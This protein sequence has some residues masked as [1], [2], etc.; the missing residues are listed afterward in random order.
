MRALVVTDGHVRIEVRPDPEPG[1]GEVLVRVRAA[2]LN[3]ADLAQRIGRYP[4]PPGSPADIPGLE[5]A[6][7]VVGHGAGVAAPAMGTRVF[8]IVGGGAQAELLAVP[9]GQ[10]AVVPDALDLVAAGGV[11]EAFLTAHDAMITISNARAGEVLFV[12]AAGS[13]VGTAAIQLGKAFGLTTV[14]SARTASKLDAAAA[15]GLDHALLAPRELDPQAFAEQL[16]AAAGPVDIALDLVGGPYPAAEVIAAATRGRIVLIG[17]MAGVPPPLEIG[18]LMAKRL[19]IQGTV[20]RPRTL[21]EKADATRAFMRDALGFFADGS[22]GPVVAEVAPLADGDAAYD[23][24]AAD[25]VF[26]KILLDCS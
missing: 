17:S 13:G 11:P 16:V 23:R 4:A 19:R 24:L 22:I 12:S 10:C 26:G 2:G 9:V 15:L 6:G 20:L 25:L 7:T 3:R 8:G 14:G 21:E 18:W 1:P 5:F